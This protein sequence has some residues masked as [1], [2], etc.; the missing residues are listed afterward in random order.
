M[1][2][3]EKKGKVGPFSPGLSRALRESWNGPGSTGKKKKRDGEGKT[4]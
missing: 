3:I 2:E 1:L 4:T